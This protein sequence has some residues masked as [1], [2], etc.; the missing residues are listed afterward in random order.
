MAFLM[1]YDN[2]G[3]HAEN[4]WLPVRAGGSS[5]EQWK[6]LV[7][8]PSLGRL[9]KRCQ[10]IPSRSWPCPW[11]WR[12]ERNLLSCSIAA[13]NLQKR[14]ADTLFLFHACL[15]ILAREDDQTLVMGE[16]ESLSLIKPESRGCRQ[17]CKPRSR[18]TG[19]TTTLR[20]DIISRMLTSRE[21]PEPNLE[22]KC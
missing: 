13:Q 3:G 21:V 4:L 8:Q 10:G 17:C 7:T 6:H 20:P 2:G 15:R 16:P 11:P 19:G 9:R 22:I 14:R 5:S 1:V 18:A 12:Y